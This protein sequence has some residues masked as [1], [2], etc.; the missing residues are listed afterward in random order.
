MRMQIG[1]CDLILELGLSLSLSLE[2]WGEEVDTRCYGTEGKRTV[3]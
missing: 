3:G 2:A 1:A